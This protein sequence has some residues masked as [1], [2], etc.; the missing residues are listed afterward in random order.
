MRGGEETNGGHANWETE[1]RGHFVFLLYQQMF[2][3]LCESVF[4]YSAVTEAGKAG[5]PLAV[6]FFREEYILNNSIGKCSQAQTG[7]FYQLVCFLLR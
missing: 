4:L 2:N 1:R 6:D 3:Q 5:E 7:V